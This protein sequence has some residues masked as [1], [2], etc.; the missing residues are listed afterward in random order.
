MN[1]MFPCFPFYDEP[2]EEILTFLGQFYEKPNHFKPKEIL[3]TDDVDLEL[4]EQL[5]KVKVLQ[6]QRGQKKDLVKLAIKNAKIALEEKFSLIE[7]G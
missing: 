4:A 2:E 6:P 1:E 7:R 5:L 3:M